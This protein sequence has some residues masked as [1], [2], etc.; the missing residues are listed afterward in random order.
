MASKSLMYRHP[1]IYNLIVKILH[2]NALDERYKII[3]REVGKNKKVMDVGCG[4]GNFARFLD[5]SCDYK[6]FDLNENFITHAKENGLNVKLGDLLDEEN[7]SDCDVTIICDIL[8]HIVPDDKKVVEMCKKVS[9]RTIICEPFSEES[10][11][12]GL[13]DKFRD[14]RLFHNLFGEADGINEFENMKEWN[15]HGKEDVIK[16][17]KDYGAGKTIVVGNDVIGIIGN[18]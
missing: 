14:N 3:A 13:L 1:K 2:G 8:H 17:M 9:K 10:F 6:G 5:T 12:E 4:T 16:L 11:L 7:Y 18:S 15:A